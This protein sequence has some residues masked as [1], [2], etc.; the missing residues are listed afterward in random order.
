[1]VASCT[2]E[3]STVTFKKAKMKE[4]LK[5]TPGSITC[6]KASCFPL[7]KEEDV[8]LGETKEDGDLKSKPTITGDELCITFKPSLQ[9]TT[10]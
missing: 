9:S 3:S 6:K 10:F 8:A 4:T 7:R 2:G 1:M 5:L